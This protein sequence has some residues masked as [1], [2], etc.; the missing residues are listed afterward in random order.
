MQTAAIRETRETKVRVNFTDVTIRNLASPAKGQVRYMDTNLPAFG[1]TVGTRTKTFFV[2]RGKQR[3]LTVVG[4]YPELSLADARKTAKR[5]LT[6]EPTKT[7]AMRL[8]AAVTLYQEDISDRLRPSSVATYNK[9]LKDPPDIALKDLK[10]TSVPLHE[11]NAI[12][13]W[14]VFCN[15][16]VREE[17]MDRNPFQHVAVV[18]GK[19][20]RVLTDAEIKAIWQYE[21]PP[22]SDI[23]K[24]CLLTGQRVGE[25][26]GFNDTWISGDT[27]TIPASVAKNGK[28]H[29]IPFNLLTARYLRRYSGQTFNGFS[30]G[31]QRMD[32]KTGVTGYTVHDLRRTF[33]TTHA[34][35]GTPIQ[36]TEKLLNHISGTISGV[37]AIYNQFQYLAETRAA[38]LQYELFIASLVSAI[39]N[40]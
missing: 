34:R 33:S 24:L 11:P 14:K 4:K 31:K 28:E 38:S 32:E 13:T 20:S 25:V 40:G 15:W 35:I 12:K 23:V 39:G 5:L 10:K 36:V 22:Y 29:T 18:Y 8:P 21:H 17:L 1:L 7:P 6:E 30:K 27:I 26:T 2:V 37:S 16:C 19:R 9:F 3:Q